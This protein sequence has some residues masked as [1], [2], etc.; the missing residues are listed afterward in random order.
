MMSIQ[1]NGYQS[2]DN[3]TAAATTITTAMINI[4]VYADEMGECNN[5]SDLNPKKE[6]HLYV[7]E[8]LCGR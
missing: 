2:Q 4:Y 5:V 6:L 1:Q 8:Y 3:S 7:S